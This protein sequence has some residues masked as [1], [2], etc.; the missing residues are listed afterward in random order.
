MSLVPFKDKRPRVHPSAYVD[1]GARLAG[2]VEIGPRC[3]VLFG[4]ALR[5]DDEPVRVLEGSVVLEQCLIEAPEGH[6]VT[7][8]PGAL[9]S[10]C[11]TVHGAVVEE[12]AL[13]GIGAIVLDGAVVGREAIVGAGAVVLPG[14]VIE[15]RSLVVGVPAKVVRG[16]T[17]EEVE[18]VR[19]EIERVLEKASVYRAYFERR[20]GSL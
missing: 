5:G 19:K 6:P 8:G 16:V 1:P 12:G 20:G 2:D 18:G 17:K 14:T 11:A 9:I 15:P 3:A 7:I 13:V 10:H 4:A